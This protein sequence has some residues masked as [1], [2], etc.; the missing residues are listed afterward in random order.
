MKIQYLFATLLGTFSF[1]LAS[2]AE[3]CTPPAGPINY[4][5]SND[6]KEISSIQVGANVV[7]QKAI[8][9]QDDLDAPGGAGLCPNGFSVS[10]DYSESNEAQNRAV[11]ACSNLFQVF[12]VSSQKMEFMV[13]NS[14]IPVC[15][16]KRLP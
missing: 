13:F 12:L 8:T 7:L 1:L 16:L 10:L 15:T 3:A 2:H 4:I 6:A 11:N 5:F 9:N 14:A